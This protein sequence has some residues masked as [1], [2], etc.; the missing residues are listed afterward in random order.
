[1]AACPACGSEVGEAVAECPRCHLGTGLFEAVRDAAGAHPSPDPT[2]L[3]TIGELL[4][5][6]D[7]DAPA[8]ST[9]VAPAGLLSRP[10]RFPAMPAASSSAV[11]APPA[12]GREAPPVAP[13]RDLPA[14][15]PAASSSELRRR[16]EEY[17]QLGR[18]LGL[19]FTDF[20]SRSESAAL[21]DDVRS[22]EVLGRE[23]FVHVASAIAEEYEG[24]LARRNELA[25][26]VPT[27]SADVELDAIR[28]AIAIGD[29]NG[30]QRRLVHVRDELGRIEEE[31]E[32][33]RILVTECDLLAQTV[34]DLG[35][36]PT[37]ALG[38]LE[39]GRRY[40]G[41][42]RRADAERMLARAA[43]ALWTL[44]QP[45]FFEDLRRIRDRMVELR[46]SG[47][48]VNPAVKEL[49]EVAA[50][51]RQRNFVGTVIAYRRLR[52]FVDRSAPPESVG[53]SELTGAVRP[54]PSA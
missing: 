6:V 25:Q 37:T 28:R 34:R 43:V 48:D 27:A 40:F 10:A 15:P 33:G 36:D 51:L 14:L 49:R 16:I 13:L 21:V 38:P 29:M 52:A 45:R 24:V 32:V 3:R 50:E 47:A 23:M 7:L 19:D 53:A 39:E 26:L 11:A 35:G 20:E 2:Y 41:K 54:S 30:A 4:A 1:M 44:L 46:S 5:T 9:P 8:A 17:F 12:M 22:L 18:R 42:G 31:W